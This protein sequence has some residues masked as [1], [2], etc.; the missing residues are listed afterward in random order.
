MLC[1]LPV[2]KQLYFGVLLTELYV[3]DA[4]RM[5]GLPHIDEM[6]DV[7]QNFIPAPLGEEI[8]TERLEFSY[9]HPWRF[10]YTNFL[11]LLLFQCGKFICCSVIHFYPILPSFFC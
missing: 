2:E 7:S 6:I 4:C 10:R 5:V 8:G 3:E 11:F 1:S 9:I